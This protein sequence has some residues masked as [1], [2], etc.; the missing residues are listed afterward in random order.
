MK[1]D[2]DIAELLASRHIPRPWMTN[3]RS[4]Q[5]TYGRYVIVRCE[6]IRMRLRKGQLSLG[7]AS[8]G[9]RAMLDAIGSISIDQMDPL[10]WLLLS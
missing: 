2:F 8:E 5:Q 4:P 10:T 7:E 1:E 6:I 3:M 9:V